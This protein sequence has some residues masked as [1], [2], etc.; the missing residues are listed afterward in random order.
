MYQTIDFSKTGGFPLTQDAMAF[1]Q[2]A[3]NNVLSSLTGVIGTYAVIN[4]VT[5]SSGN[6]SA[7]WVTFNGEIVPFEAA[8]A[9]KG[10]NV[11]VIE[12]VTSVTYLNSSLQGVIKSRK[13]VLGA[14]GIPIGNFT[15]LTLES[16]NAKAE[17]ALLAA[18]NALTVANNAL[19]TANNALTIA[20][21]A[22]S[23]ASAAALPSG[24]IAA[25]KPTIPIPS[26]WV[27][28]NGANGTPDL[29]G[30]V[31]NGSGG[32]FVAYPVGDPSPQSV[33]DGAAF[34]TNFRSLIVS[35]L[36]PH[37]H[38]IR[39]QSGGDNDDH[40]NT[41]AFAYGDKGIGEAPF[42][43]TNTDNCLSTGSN[44]VLGIMQASPFDIRQPFIGLRFIMKT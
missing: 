7:G 26:G 17:A 38:D 6:Y 16:I 9:S 19:T 28:C 22:L 11:D 39:A 4:G 5:L 42:S 41:T 2:N 1:L 32:D 25:I 31:I 21:N 23:A 33:N 36:P 10:P 35:N 40:N 24:T 29:R 14:S 15:R 44:P 30:R 18:N 20:N 12:T 43:V 13:A 27:L 37:V 3:Y 34:G 8:P